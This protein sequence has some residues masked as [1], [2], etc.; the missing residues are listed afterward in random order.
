MDERAETSNMK[1][2][3]SALRQAQRNNQSDGGDALVSHSEF[4]LGNE[5]IIY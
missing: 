2:C 5:S 1:S 3:H 4:Y